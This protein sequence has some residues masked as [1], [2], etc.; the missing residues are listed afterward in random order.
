MEFDGFI[1]TVLKGGIVSSVGIFGS[2]LV[3]TSITQLLREVSLE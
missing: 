2:W 3:N 1:E